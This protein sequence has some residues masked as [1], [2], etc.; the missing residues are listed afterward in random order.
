MSKERRYHWTGKTSSNET[1]S[2]DIQ[3]QNLR[4]AK[5]KLLIQGIE[6]ISIRR[7]APAV[8][9]TIHPIK[10]EHVVSF[11]RQLAT[12][13][14]AN[15]PIAQALSNIALGQPNP[16]FKTL[17]NDIRRQVETGISLSAALTDH[18]GQFNSLQ[19]SMIRI[20]EQSGTLDIVM[21]QLA[22]H[23]EKS[24][25]IRRKVKSAMFYPLFVLGV[26]ILILAILLIAV[27]PQ[28]EL[29]FNDF[30]T[31]L[32]KLTLFVLAVSEFLST[33]WMLILLL[34]FLTYFVGL[35][36]YRKTTSIRHILDLIKL[37]I[38]VFGPLYGAALLSRFSNTLS[39]MFGSGITLPAAITTI[40]DVIPNHIYQSALYFVRQE[41]ASGKR[42]SLALAE[43]KVFPPMVVK[44]IE[45]AEHAG[46]LE[47]MLLRIADFYDRQLDHQVDAITRLIEPILIVV[48]GVVVG[49]IMIAVYLPIFSL[50]AIFQI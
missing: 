18:P 22:S 9:L 19:V 27:V 26:A 28:F 20:A 44:M 32:P 5:D 47:T 13:I 31:S 4:D 46:E 37:N 50:G 49:V 21:D 41:I 40:A 7:N 39:I 45:T 36:G 12:M 29:L 48:L 6:I 24:D 15:I 30:G 8:R 42:L 16:R 34:I 38:P 25:T 1:L 10:S 11:F 43:T 17:I 35:F 33:K 14:N 3:G 23:L 2:G